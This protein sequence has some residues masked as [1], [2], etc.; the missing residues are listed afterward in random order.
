VA[1]FAFLVILDLGY[2]PW[3]AAGRRSD[4]A[5]ACQPT[6][7]RVGR[8]WLRSKRETSRMDRLVRCATPGLVEAEIVSGQ[9]EA[10]QWKPPRKLDTGN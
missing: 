8:T 3:G 10:D 1:A 4:P 6:V 7:G 2:Y 5:V 9:K